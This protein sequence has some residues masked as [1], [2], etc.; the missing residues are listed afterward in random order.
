[1]RKCVV[2]TAV[3][4][5]LMVMVAPAA[6]AEELGVGIDITYADRYVWRGIPINEEAVLQPSIDLSKGGFNLNA[7]GN[8]DLTD[9]GESDD[10]PYGDYGDE[11]GDFTEIDYTG[12]YSAE[13]GKAILSTGFITYTFPNHTE[14][15]TGLSTTEIFFGLGFDVPLSPSITTYID[16][17]NQG[18]GGSEG[19]NYTSFD[20]GHS[21]E[22][23]SADNMSLGLDF[24]GHLG[25]ANHKFLK[26]YYGINEESDFHDWSASAG[27][28]ISLP[29]G[30]YIT[31]AYMYTSLMEDESVDLLDDNTELDT[32]TGI[33]M[34]SVG[35]SGEI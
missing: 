14:W 10:N 26:F 5:M 29:M 2:L 20:M 9:W 34:V 19:A 13:V 6:M 27:L 21:F 17:D 22:L 35:W 8:M 7:W 33:F 30:I 25:Y 31:P 28:P 16:V 23:Y 1:M 32:A 15:G 3:M 24:S 18:K 12:G 4:G 11:S